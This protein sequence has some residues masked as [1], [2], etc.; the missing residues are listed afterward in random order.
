LGEWAAAVNRLAPLA[1]PILLA[2]VLL[3]GMM[4]VKGA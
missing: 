2:Q 4:I 3:V 1:P